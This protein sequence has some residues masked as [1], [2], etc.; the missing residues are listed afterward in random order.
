[1]ESSSQGLLAMTAN[2]VIHV[3]QVTFLI[4]GVALVEGMDPPWPRV[5]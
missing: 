1:M 3:P 5:F 4:L 2:S